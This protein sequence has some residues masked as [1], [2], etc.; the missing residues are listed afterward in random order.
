MFTLEYSL[1]PIPDTNLEFVCGRMDNGVHAFVYQFMRTG[2]GTNDK[3][4]CPLDDPV[5]L[6]H[7]FA[8]EIGHRFGLSDSGCSD[9]VMGKIPL[10][11]D[12]TNV[13]QDECSMAGQLNTT[14]TERNVCDNPLD[15]HQSPILLTCEPRAW[16]LSSLAGGVEF[17]YDADGNKTRTAWTL[18]GVATGFLFTD[19]DGTGCAES[20]AEL[21]G[22]NR[23]IGELDLAANGF[24]ALA[25]YDSNFDGTI[26]SADANWSDFKVWIDSSHDG[27]CTPDEVLSLDQFGLVALDLHYHRSGYVDRF[28]NQFRLASSA[29]CRTQ[30]GRLNRRQYFD[31]FFL[32]SGQD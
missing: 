18:A 29:T 31:V 24:E 7:I 15:C 1:G 6:Q 8:H 19:L 16:D 13:R 32:T 11:A 9:H 14:A 2:P 22:D 28:G 5:K 12:T 30:D 26:T 25:S 10:G 27:V 4:P 17:D 21:F 23:R 20:G 3:A